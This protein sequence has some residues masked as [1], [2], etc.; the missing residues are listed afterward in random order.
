M[1]LFL[2]NN[3]IKI[4]LNI[5]HLNDILIKNQYLNIKININIFIMIFPHSNY[6]K[7]Y[8]GCMFSGK[9]TNLLNEITKYKILTDKI[10]VINHIL[11]KKR[12]QPNNSSGYLKTHNNKMCPAIMLNKLSELHIDYIELYKM[13][14]IIIIDEGQF[15]EDLYDFIKNELNKIDTRK[16]FIIGGLSGDYNMNTLGDIYR[17]I[18]LADEINKLSAYCV[19]CKDGTLASFTKRTIKNENQILVGDSDIYIPVCRYHHI[20]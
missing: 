15:F 14:D 8:I 2:N 5:N 18:P 12:Q 20:N 3:N 13:A 6:L 19:E 16:I 4:H 9:S 17:L 7:L 1:C 10:I 11:D